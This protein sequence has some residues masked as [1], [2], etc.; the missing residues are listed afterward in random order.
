L[1]FNIRFISPAAYVAAFSCTKCHCQKLI[2]RGALLLFV[3]WNFTCTL[4]ALRLPSDPRLTM[5]DV[6]QVPAPRRT[7]LVVAAVPPVKVGASTTRAPVLLRLL[8][9]EI[10]PGDKL[11]EKGPDSPTSEVIRLRFLATPKEPAPVLRSQ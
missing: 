11:P 5:P 8:A 3:V 1:I 10:V 4:V 6:A 2:F 9:A 7:W